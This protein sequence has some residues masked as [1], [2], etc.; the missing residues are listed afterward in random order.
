MLSTCQGLI[1]KYN[2]IRFYEVVPW[3][4]LNSTEAHNMT[5]FELYHDGTLERTFENFFDAIEYAEDRHWDSQDCEIV[6]ITTA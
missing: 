1:D 2:W 4:Y 3:A 6:E 5:V